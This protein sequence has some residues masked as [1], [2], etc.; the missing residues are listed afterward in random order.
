M[1]G[2]Q[3]KRAKGSET[4]HGAA[5]QPDQ[6]QQEEHPAQNTQ[7]ETKSTDAASLGVGGE[8][9]EG[10]SALYG[11]VFV[12]NGDLKCITCDAWV[13]PTD[14]TFGLEGW[15]AVDLPVNKPSKPKD[16]GLGLGDG[17]GERRVARWEGW[18]RSKPNCPWILLCSVEADEAQA[19]RDKVC[20]R[21]RP[22][23]QKSTASTA[24][25]DLTPQPAHRQVD[26]KWYVSA[27]ETFLDEVAADLHGPPEAKT[28]ANPWGYKPAMGRAKPL[29]LVPL[30]GTGA[31]GF[32]GCPGK[33]TRPTNKSITM[34]CWAWVP[35]PSLPPP[36]PPTFHLTPSD[37]LLLSQVIRP[38]IE[39]LLSA[40]QKHGFDVA[41]VTRD[42]AK[43]AACQAMRRQMCASHADDGASVWA[44]LPEEL[45]QQAA[46]LAD[47]AVQDKLALFMGAGASAAA[48]L[49]L[50]M[51]LLREL[52]EDLSMSESERAELLCTQTDPMDAATVIEKRYLAE[53][54]GDKFRHAVAGLLACKKYP[55]MHALVAALSCK[56][57]V[58]TN[59]D[60][61]AEQASAAIGVKVAV[62]PH[63][64]AHLGGR[65]ILK[66]HGCVSEPKTIVL[67]RQDYMR[68]ND[69][70]A[71]LSSIV[72][73]LLITR[74]MVFLGFS[75]RDDN[76]HRSRLL[77]P[78]LTL[79][80]NTRKPKM[81]R[82]ANHSHDP[83]AG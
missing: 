45:K 70:R 56:C 26:A 4:K 18:D 37:T 59:Y 58:T 6:Q 21:E 47:L 15:E 25:R 14:K 12:I 5:Q 29:V 53:G 75:L 16:W 28:S 83:P 79:D 34:L 22:A 54:K 3:S 40:V 62:L 32:G 57:L 30:V 52:S 78:D 69:R 48:G 19:V 80:D 51:D 41:L 31:G 39:L 33:V 67:S 46:R 7:K 64:P 42:R 9:E 1:G 2:G 49:P 77:P 66:L 11:H 13:L 71:A 23:P 20:S 68:F 76:F 74:H 50:W 60:T 61:M 38:L 72:Q 63:K 55:L 43:F 65:W 81:R 73:A 17:G 36:P 24:E 8:G 27:V 44:G 35:S 82:C 10:A